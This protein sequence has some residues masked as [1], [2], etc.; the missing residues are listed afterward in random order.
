[1]SKNLRKK[2][3]WKNYLVFIIFG[4]S[5]KNISDDLQKVLE[6]CQ[7]CILGVQRNI[8]CE[9]IFLNYCILFP[10]FRILSKNFSGLLLE[11]L[12]PRCQNCVVCVQKEVLTKSF[13]KPCFFFILLGF[14]SNFYWLTDRILSAGL[15]KLSFCMS[16]WSFQGKFN[17]W[18]RVIV[19]SVLRFRAKNFD[20]VAET[21]FI[22]SGG[23]FRRFSGKLLWFL[24]FSDIH[25]NFFRSFTENFSAGLSKCFLC[26]QRIFLG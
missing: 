8:W 3:F 5:S 18:K 7:N 2:A 14:Y 25:Q 22:V 21:I 23:S 4:L 10:A 19:F 24:F 15:S 17:L 20:N 13:C 6:S 12:R 26:V 16:R 1:M 11:G 9:C